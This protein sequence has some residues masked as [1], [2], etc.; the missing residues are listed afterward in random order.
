MFDA[1]DRPEELPPF[2]QYQVIQR[3][4]EEIEILAVRPHPFS[5]EEEARVERYMRQTLGHPFA[6][7]LRRVDAI[8]R[9]R[10]GKYEDFICDIP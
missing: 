7:T 4:L 5:K 8:P 9:S 1:G 3:S 6:V 2:F 10:T